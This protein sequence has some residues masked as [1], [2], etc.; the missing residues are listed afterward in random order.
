MAAQGAPH[1]HN[2]EHGR[3]IYLGDD[4]GIDDDDGDYGNLNNSKTWSMSSFDNVGQNSHGRS[5]ALLDRTAM[6]YFFHVGQFKFI[7]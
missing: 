4:L 2:E 6:Y 5:F 1:H 3:P 7:F